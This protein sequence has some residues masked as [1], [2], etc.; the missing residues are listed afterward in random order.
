M[1][2]S[3][4]VGPILVEDPLVV[5]DFLCGY[6]AHQVEA[7]IGE[8]APSVGSVGCEA[9]LVDQ[10]GMVCRGLHFAVVAWFAST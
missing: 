3:C 1:D 5:V 6:A 9:V 7:E 4:L 2:P 10:R 8:G